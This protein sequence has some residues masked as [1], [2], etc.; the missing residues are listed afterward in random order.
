MVCALGSPNGPRKQFNLTGSDVSAEY[1]KH[2]SLA[3][4]M[5]LNGE[6][7]VY[8]VDMI[9]SAAG[10]DTVADEIYIGGQTTNYKFYRSTLLTTAI[11]R[12]IKQAPIKIPRAL[13]VL[14]KQVTS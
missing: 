2:P 11:D 5:A 14:F 9:Y 1:L 8:I 3:T 10:T 13:P 6:Q 4:E 12:Y 7:D